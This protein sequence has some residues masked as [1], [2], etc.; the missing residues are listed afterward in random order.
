MPCGSQ[1]ATP[2]ILFIIILILHSSGPFFIGVEVE[3]G[4]RTR[5]GVL[6]SGGVREQQALK[7][8]HGEWGYWVGARPSLV[9]FSETL[10]QLVLQAVKLFV[11]APAVYVQTSPLKP[12]T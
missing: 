4:V 8:G 7:P 5:E 9:N 11:S 3:Q 10:L 1:S 2:G 6:H 12:H